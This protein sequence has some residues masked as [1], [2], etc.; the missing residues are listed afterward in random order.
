MGF[1]RRA[2]TKESK[3]SS[4]CDEWACLLVHLPLVSSVHLNSTNYVPS[5]RE[6]RKL[7]LHQSNITHPCCYR[8]CF[9]Q[10]ICKLAIMWYFHG[11]KNW[12]QEWAN[13]LVWALEMW[14]LP[15][16]SERP[17]SSGWD[18]RSQFF[19]LLNTVTSGCESWD[20]CSFP[21]Q[22]IMSKKAGPRTTDLPKPHLITA[23]PLGLFGCTSQLSVTCSLTC[24][25]W[26]FLQ[27]SLRVLLLPIIP[28][29][30]ATHFPAQGGR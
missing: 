7:S 15:G 26:Y 8:N 22:T 23:I 2:K 3:E 21:C 17:L 9:W 19:F 25:K 28:S 24:A 5:K 20:C 27:A 30:L 1:I 29:Y 16:P 13:D 14:C 4:V 11:H 10:L 12:I 6:L 18:T